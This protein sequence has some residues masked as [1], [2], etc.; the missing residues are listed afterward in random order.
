MG[1]VP[2][3]VSWLL[4]LLDNVHNRFPVGPLRLLELDCEKVGPPQENIPG[5]CCGMYNRGS[6]CISGDSSRLKRSTPQLKQ[7]VLGSNIKLRHVKCVIASAKGIER[8]CPYLFVEN[9]LDP[10]RSR[11]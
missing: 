2:K 11:L 1:A 5:A 3:S 4:A 7:L 6:T 10:E 9:T 8:T